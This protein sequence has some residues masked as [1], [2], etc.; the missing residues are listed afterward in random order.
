MP[1]KDPVIL[2]MRVGLRSV[3]FFLN[4][5]LGAPADA[6]SGGRTGEPSREDLIAFVVSCGFVCVYIES[7]SR[8]FDDVAS[9]DPASDLNGSVSFF[10]AAACEEEPVDST[11]VFCDIVGMVKK[12]VSDV[13]DRH[14]ERV[15]G[16]YLRLKPAFWKRVVIVRN[17]VLWPG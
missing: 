12:D 7:M 3:L 5:L 10:P 8:L 15:T 16:C 9:A 11:P 6:V 13:S 17:I 4:L 2:A 1:A 14:W